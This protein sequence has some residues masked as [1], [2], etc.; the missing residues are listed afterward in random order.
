MQLELQTVRGFILVL[1]YIEYFDMK[2]LKISFILIIVAAYT[3]TSCETTTYEEISADKIDNPTYTANVKAIISN[4]CLSCHS[5]V[6]DQYPE[7]E[8]YEQVKDAVQKGDVICRIDTQSCG[9][10][11]PQQGRMPQ[12]NINI[13]KQWVN[14]GFTK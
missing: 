6:G 1:I 10:V 2:A 13:I 9:E 3:W 5:K 4:N 11:M 7:M 12:I 14:T 8:S